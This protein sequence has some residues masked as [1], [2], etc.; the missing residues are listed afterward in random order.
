MSAVVAAAHTTVHLAGVAAAAGGAKAVVA[1]RTQMAVTLAFHIILAC[2]GVAFPGVVLAAHYRGLR[3]PRPGRAAARAPL[4]QGDGR[5]GRGGRGDRHGAVVDGAALARAP[6][7]SSARHRHPV[8]RGGHL[9]LPRGRF[10]R[11][12]VRLGPAAAV[13][14]FWTGVPIVIAGALGTLSVV[15]ANSWMNQP[16][17]FTLS[18]G[19]IT[20]VDPWAVMFNRAALYEIPRMLLA[21]YMVVGFGVAAIYAAGWLRG[22]RSHYHRLGLLIPFVIAAVAT[23]LPPIIEEYAARA[24]AHQQPIK[25]ASMEYVVHT[26]RGVTEWM[27][28]V[29][30]AARRSSGCRSQD[31]DSVLV[32]MSPRTKVTGWDSVPARL[33]PPM[34]WLIH[35]A[36]D[37]MVGLGFFLL[38]A[39]AWLGAYW[40][41]RRH[42]PGTRWFFAAVL[43]SGPAAIIAMECGWIVHRGRAPA[44]GGGYGYIDH[45]PGGHDGWR[46]PGQPGP[47]PAH[48]R[49]AR[50][51]HLRD[52]PG[53]GPALGQR[54]EPG[55]RDVPYGPAASSQPDHD[56]VVLV[57]ADATIAVLWVSAPYST[58]S[59]AAPTS[60]AACGTCWP[61]GPPAAWCSPAP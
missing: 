13:G 6:W 27:G 1:A 23:P 55:E 49:G 17:S 28:G 18:H 3:A 9:L 46:G 8:L 52:H 41:R 38:L 32:G 60:A 25:F 36:F 39:G 35:S 12:P 20:A 58:P 59:W 30:Y 26:H 44:L 33:R 24:V 51:G 22:R 50:G 42:L 4:V 53:H 15:S 40:W 5:A 11:L 45:L 47:H 10:R 56:Q 21:A 54:Q 34:P 16:G 2:F 43:A 37:L 29:V 48:V 19:K 14:T 7:A 61:A 57:T 31:F